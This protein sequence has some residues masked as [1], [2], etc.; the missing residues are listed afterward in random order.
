MPQEKILPEQ[1]PIW[2]AHRDTVMYL[3]A[4][5]EVQLGCVTFVVEDTVLDRL[6]MSVLLGTDVP[7]L[8]ELLN[9]LG[10]GSG[11]TSDGGEAIDALVMT[12]SQQ[13]TQERAEEE[14][15]GKQLRS[16]VRPSPVDEVAVE[17]VDPLGEN[18]DDGVA[19]GG[20]MIGAKFDDAPFSSRRVRQKMTRAQKWAN[21]RNHRGERPCLQLGAF[22]EV[23]LTRAEV[24]RLQA[25]DPTLVAVRAASDVFYQA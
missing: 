21:K 9:G 24:E 22:E 17:A 4:N 5:I 25:E 7:S 23:N 8:V 15:R 10:R 1:V 3:L 12:R 13:A 18:P 11:M 19:E 20:V 6:P 14:Q 16:G 2:C